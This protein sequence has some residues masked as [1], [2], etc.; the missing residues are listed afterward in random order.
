[1]SPFSDLNEN[2][3]ECSKHRSFHLD[4]YCE[5]CDVQICAECV[6][7]F[8]IVPSCKVVALTDISKK[9]QEER[10]HLL[11]LLK[12]IEIQCSTIE[13]ERRVIQDFKS[14]QREVVQSEVLQR[15]TAMHDLLEKHKERLLRELANNRLNVEEEYNK[16]V[17][18]LSEFQ[19]RLRCLEEE[20]HGITGENIMSIGEIHQLKLR[21]E[22]AVVDLEKREID[23]KKDHDRHL[24]LTKVTNSCMFCDLQTFIL[25]GSVMIHY[26][27]LV[28]VF[29][30]RK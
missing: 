12:S 9:I 19:A 22:D 15:A 23:Y 26:N 16:K 7:N 25:I 6:F 11:R 1:M 29:D 2:F 27:H 13:N 21:V 24:S 20:L 10:Q 30:G 3:K 14:N 4:K 5:T 17:N 18:L 28:H 8:R